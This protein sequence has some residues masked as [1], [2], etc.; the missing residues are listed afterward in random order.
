MDT[1][2]TRYSGWQKGLAMVTPLGRSF[3]TV[4][5]AS[6]G[7]PAM[8]KAPTGAVV[9]GEA[10]GAVGLARGA[11]FWRGG[12]LGC[13]LGFE[14]CFERAIKTGHMTLLYRGSSR[15]G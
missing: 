13:K 5:A 6:S 3:F 7:S 11:L 14:A 4:R 10:L 1:R 15:D 12:D 2:E 9:L 8:M